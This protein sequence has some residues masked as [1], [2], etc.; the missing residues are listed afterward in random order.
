MFFRASRT[1]KNTI[2]RTSRIE[3]LV[4][5]L[6]FPKNQVLYTYMCTQLRSEK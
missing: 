2:L 3:T 6:I 1:N 4:Y 5:F